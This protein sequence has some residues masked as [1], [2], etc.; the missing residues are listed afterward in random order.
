MSANAILNKGI[1]LYMGG[2]PGADGK[3]V[4]VLNIEGIVKQV[5]ALKTQN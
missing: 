5:Q 1:I 4:L 3:S 2:T